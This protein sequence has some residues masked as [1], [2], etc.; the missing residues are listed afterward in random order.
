MLGN[1]S[2]QSARAC[3]WPIN[4][5]LRA[6]YSLLPIACSLLPTDIVQV[7]LIADWLRPYGIACWYRLLVI[8]WYLVL[9]IA[10]RF[11]YFALCLLPTAVTY[12]VRRTAAETSGVDRWSPKR[13]SPRRGRG[14]T[15]GSRR[16]PSGRRRDDSLSTT[17]LPSP[18]TW[19]SY[20]R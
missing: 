3:P 6:I 17:P 11:S 18:K 4:D 20:R 14:S 2:C 1:M 8:T 10:Y 19:Q 16:C 5:G 7:M 9:I 15:R 13:R 12:L